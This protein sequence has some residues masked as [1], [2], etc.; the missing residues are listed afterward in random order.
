MPA[1]SFDFSIE[2]GSDF[3]VVFRY[4]DENQ[5]SVNLKN[6][7]VLLRMQDDTGVQHVFDNITKTD[8]YSFVATEDGFITLDIPAKVTDNYTFATAQY[9]L[10]I[11]EPNE[12][13][14]GAGTKSN[15]ILFGNVSVIARLLDPPTRSNLTVFP[16]D[17]DLCPPVMLSDAIVYTGGSLTVVDDSVVSNTISI[18]DTRNIKNIEIGLVGINHTNI[19]DLNIF[20][21]YP[22]SEQ[23]SILLVGSQKFLNYSP[24]FSFILSDRAPENTSTHNVQNG[25][26]CRTTDKTNYIRFRIPVLGDASGFASGSGSGSGVDEQIIIG[27]D[28]QI[29]LHSFDSIIGSPANGDWTLYVCDHDKNAIGF[30]HSWRLYITYEDLF[31]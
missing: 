24:G 21:K 26:M 18:S 1:A 3:Q 25:G 28:N 22:G 11:Q 16:A 12:V 14:V 9:E 4:L 17:Q 6:M 5:N 20:L 8:Q 31:E 19:Q 29:P 15:R 30:L 2:Q 23:Y 10:D 27:Y 7:Y 13:F